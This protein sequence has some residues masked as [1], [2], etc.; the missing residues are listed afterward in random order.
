L[1]VAGR[2]HGTRTAPRRL[3]QGGRSYRYG[4]APTTALSC[5]APRKRKAQNVPHDSSRSAE[6]HGGAVE[7]TT[8]RYAIVP[9]WV[10]SISVKALVAYVA[11]ARYANGA[12]GQCHPKLATLADDAG[13]CVNSIRAGIDD[14]VAAGAVV[15]TER[16]SDRDGSRLA[17]T[18]QLRIDQPLPPSTTCVPPLHH[19]EGA[20]PPHDTQGLDEVELEQT[21]DGVCES[22]I[23]IAEVLDAFCDHYRTATDGRE[24]VVT[25]VWRRE[26]RLMLDGPGKRPPEWTREQLVHAIR[27]LDGPTSDAQFWSRNVLCPKKLRLQMPRL[28]AAIR[29]ERNGTTRGGA[30]RQ[31]TA[32]LAAM[33]ARLDGTAA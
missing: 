20:P 7:V 1:R 31:T 6:T 19:M 2:S 8:T 26:V 11:L 23:D 9:L 15:V 3:A 21:P 22:R 12:T 10:Q 28:A 27:W 5:P 4:V 24:P 33:A 18:Y 16:Y 17:N 13:C 32:D 25:K 14:L 30:P 29:A